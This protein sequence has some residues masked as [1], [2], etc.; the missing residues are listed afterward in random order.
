MSL[1]SL[2][3]IYFFLFIQFINKEEAQGVP[4]VAQWVKI[5]IAAARVAVEMGFDS[6]PSLAQWVKGSNIVTTA[7]HR[8]QIIDH[9]FGL[10]SIP[11]PG[12]SICPG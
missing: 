9:S 6:Q 5:P 1:P 2:L 8:S 7:D 12:T 11:R 3:M 4:V 10:D